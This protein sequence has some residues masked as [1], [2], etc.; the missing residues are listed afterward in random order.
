MKHS[1][2]YLFGNYIKWDRV[3]ACDIYLLFKVHWEAQS[4]VRTY[5]S[6]GIFLSFKKKVYLLYVCGTLVKI[7][8]ELDLLPLCESWK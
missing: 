2:F 4:T 7:K 3:F 6:F 1:S 8:W 5:K